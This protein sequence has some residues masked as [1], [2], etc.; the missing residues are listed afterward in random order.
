MAVLV[1]L[2]TPGVVEDLMQ[3]AKT[4]LTDE[5]LIRWAGPCL[6]HMCWL[7]CIHHAGLIQAGFVACNLLLFGGTCK[8]S[9][10]GFA[11]SEKTNRNHTRQLCGQQQ[12]QLSAG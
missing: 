12:R 9:L 5:R 2:L 4:V 6:L 8:L 11:A 10:A 3:L 1:A 7:C